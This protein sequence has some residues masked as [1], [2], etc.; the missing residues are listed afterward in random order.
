MSSWI[1]PQILQIYEIN[2]R[3]PRVQ[4]KNWYNDREPI[5]LGLNY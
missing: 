2:P 3:R 1:K 5:M 4:P